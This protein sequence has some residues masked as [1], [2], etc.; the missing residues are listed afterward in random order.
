M[1]EFHLAYLNLGSN[2]EPE[3]NLVRALDLLYADGGVL[4]V[5]TAWETEAVDAKGGNYLNACVLYR[6]PLLQAELKERVIRPIEA[7]LGRQR[8]EDKFAPR[9][10][11]IDIVL[12]D[13]ALCNPLFW[14]YV[15]V[16]VPLAEI[17][18]QYRNSLLQEAVTE[19][20]ARLRSQVWI[21]ARP[22]VLSRFR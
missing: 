9:T 17:Y 21:K 12:F 8:G 22:E 3:K 19:A 11:D 10:I 14:Q 7:Q 1:N 18:P 4:K 2:I 5:S 15:F 20:A 16:V 13:D 6:T